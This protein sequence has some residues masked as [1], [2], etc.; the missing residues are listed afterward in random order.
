M[1]IGHLSTAYHTSLLLQGGE[2][3]DEVAP[4]RPKWI[5]FGGGPA[6]IDALAKGDLDIGYAG[7]PPAM[8]GMSH[9]S[10]IKCVAGGHM[11]CTVLV[12][13]SGY[14]AM[15]EPGGMR[16]TLEQF[17]GQEIGSP[18]RGSIHDVILRY[19]LRKNRVNAEVKNFDWSDFIPLAMERG[20]IEAAVGTPALA[21][22]L[23]TDLNAKIMVPAQALWPNNPSY[24]II[25]REDFIEEH[26]EELETFLSLHR[27]ASDF[28]RREPEKAAEVAARTIG[29]V[30]ASFIRDTYKISPRYCAALSREFIEST[31]DFASVMKDLGYLSKTMRKADVFET[32]FI[33]KIHPE[34]P[35]Y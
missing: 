17:R 35:H 12:A 2:W 10:R 23:M 8:I 28:I 32:S 6:L 5:L 33:E 27:N 30:D 25:A 7:L 24:G 15:D 3:V 13:K 18:P 16:E 29:F 11:D 4:L 26:P 21:V 31:M 22:T 14:K 34:R 1:R 19:L 9:G 20:E